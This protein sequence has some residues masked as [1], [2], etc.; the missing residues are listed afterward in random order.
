MYQLP[1]P[2]LPAKIRRLSAEVGRSTLCVVVR[3][4]EHTVVGRFTLDSRAT[5]LESVS[6]WLQFVGRAARIPEDYPLAEWAA[7]AAAKMLDYCEAQRAP[8]A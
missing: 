7:N 4:R 8:E 5:M 1:E 2:E 6:D 3:L